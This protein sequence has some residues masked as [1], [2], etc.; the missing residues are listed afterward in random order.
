MAPLT[1]SLLEGGVHLSTGSTVSSARLPWLQPKEGLALSQLLRRS[2]H[3]APLGGTLACSERRRLQP[4]L[5]CLAS[6]C[7]EGHLL[8]NPSSLG[9]S[10]LRQ[11]SYQGSSAEK[12]RAPKK[13]PRGCLGHR[14]ARSAN[15]AR[16]SLA[17]NKV[18]AKGKRTEDQTVL[19]PIKGPQATH[20]CDRHRQP[21]LWPCEFAG[22]GRSQPTTTGQRG[23]CAHTPPI[24]SCSRGNKS[25]SQWASG[26]PQALALSWKP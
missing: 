14:T 17:L 5:H 26:R 22:G 9:D 7:A 12:F 1:H 4:P 16:W 3:C 2:N 19:A 23:A 11:S 24:R 8:V 13:F 25:V 18:A 6:H 21:T 15:P 20:R 10:K